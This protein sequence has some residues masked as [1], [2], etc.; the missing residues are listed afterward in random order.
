KQL[1]H[2][3][4][5]L[6]KD[7]SADIKLCPVLRQ[8][9]KNRQIQDALTPQKEQNSAPAGFH[10]SQNS[11]QPVCTV[12]PLDQPDRIVIPVQRITS[13]AFSCCFFLLFCA[14]FFFF[15]QII[16]SNIP[17]QQAEN[18]KGSVKF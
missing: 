3:R 1:F 10:V 16:Y 5:R 2:R 13:S 9:G 18:G 14:L 4:I 11:G 8:F 12:L 6:R 17:Q 15:I 7:V